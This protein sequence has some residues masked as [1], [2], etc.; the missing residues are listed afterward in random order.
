MGVVI[1][2][3]KVIIDMEVWEVGNYKFTETGTRLGLWI[4]TLRTSLAGLAQILMVTM[5]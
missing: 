1:L 5:A 3:Y 4:I 2:F